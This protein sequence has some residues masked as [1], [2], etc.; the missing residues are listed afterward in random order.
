MGLTKDRQRPDYRTLRVSIGSLEMLKQWLDTKMLKGQSLKPILKGARCTWPPQ[1]LTMVHVGGKTDTTL[2]I[3][4][5][6]I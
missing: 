6:P 5:I 1:I 4:S 3:N 2:E